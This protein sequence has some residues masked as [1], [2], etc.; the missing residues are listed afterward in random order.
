LLRVIFFPSKPSEDLPDFPSYYNYQN[1]VLY[2]LTRGADPFIADNKDRNCFHILGFKGLT[3]CIILILNFLRHKIR[4]A[5]L[6]SL[7][8]YKKDYGFLKSDIKKGVLVSPNQSLH[9]VQNNFHQFMPKVVEV[10]AN[11]YLHE[12]SGS[13]NDLIS[14]SIKSKREL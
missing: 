3:E 7:K 8:K 14:R 1:I 13:R 4:K 2:L 6:A 12:V 5:A 9:S 10:F 11:E